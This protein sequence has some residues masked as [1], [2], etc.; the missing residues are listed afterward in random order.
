MSVRLPWNQEFAG[1]HEGNV[2]RYRLKADDLAALDRQERR[3]LSDIGPLLA[4][5]YA[6]DIS[7]ASIAVG[8]N[9]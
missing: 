9:R 7:A 3:Y 6:R 2:I 1:L 8:D 4:S 5:G